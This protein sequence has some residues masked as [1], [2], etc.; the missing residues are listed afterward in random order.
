[1]TRINLTLRVFLA[2]VLG[3]LLLPA[4]ALADVVD[5]GQSTR[6]VLPTAQINVMVL[7]AVVPL[8]TYL[9]NKAAPWTGQGVKAFVTVLVSAAVAGA[10]QAIDV[11]NFGWNSETLQLIASSVLA[12]LMAHQWLWKPSGVQGRLAEPVKVGGDIPRRP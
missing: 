2:A 1:M 10:Y 7:G 12:T 3:L 9:L 4:L 11:G 6:L 5:P 8:L